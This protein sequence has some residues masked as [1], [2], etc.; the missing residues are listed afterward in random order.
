MKV[1]I[2]MSRLSCQMWQLVKG[3]RETKFLLGK[4]R[5]FV[6]ALMGLI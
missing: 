3:E 6:P 4:S 1:W 5:F 2:V